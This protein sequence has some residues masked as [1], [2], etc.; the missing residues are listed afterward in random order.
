MTHCKNAFNNSLHP[1]QNRDAVF[2]RV[3]L[4]LC[5]AEKLLVSDSII[6]AGFSNMELVDF[7]YHIEWESWKDSSIDLFA[8]KGEKTR[9]LRFNG[10]SNL[11][12]AEGFSG[13]LS[14]MLVVDISARQWDA[15]RVEV[16]N[17]EQDPVSE[18]GVYEKG[19]RLHYRGGKKGSGYI[20]V[21]A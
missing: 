18:K 17:I 7:H 3:S 6:L 12:I 14:G 4:A 9:H 11:K 21:L 13:S 2:G 20:T 1:T 10:V 8:K 15:S 16:Q 5:V 19:V